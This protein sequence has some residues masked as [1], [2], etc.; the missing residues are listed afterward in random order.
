MLSGGMGLDGHND[1]AGVKFPPPLL[2][3]AFL[4]LGILASLW[5]P[6]YLLPP[7][8]AWTL[9][10]VMLASGVVLGPIWGVRTLRMAGTTIRPDKATAKLVTD[11]PFRFSRNPLYLALTL[12][13]VGFALIA[14]SV[15][16]L[17]LLLPVIL[18]M[19]RFVIRREEEYLARTFG[20]EYA[21][22]KMNVRRW[23]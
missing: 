9:G 12:M 3:I 21:H 2:Y 23:I 20:D 17:F 10:G 18:I 4:I 5:H 8:L 13:Y 11:G 22:Y 7:A 15:W 19:S 6:F 14:N 16:A 1:S